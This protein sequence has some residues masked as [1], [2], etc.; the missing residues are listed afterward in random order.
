MR[1]S[2]KKKIQST[3]NN[4]QIEYYLKY[5]EAKIWCIY[6]TR[7]R[8]YEFVGHGHITYSGLIVTFEN[9]N[10]YKVEYIK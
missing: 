7:W 4:I 9:Y 3:Y 10:G 8:Y 2:A 5:K 6:D 1:I